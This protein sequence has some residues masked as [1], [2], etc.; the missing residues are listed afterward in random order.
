MLFRS[1]DFWV[2][3]PEKIIYDEILG[4]LSLEVRETA[5]RQR[6][7]FSMWHEWE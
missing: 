4:L 1:L 2:Q 7:I 3:S 5:T 6:G